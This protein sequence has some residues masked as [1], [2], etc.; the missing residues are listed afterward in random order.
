MRACLAT[1]NCLL[2]IWLNAWPKVLSGLA[3]TRSRSVT[4][5]FRGGFLTRSSRLRLRVS[6]GRSHRFSSHIARRL[7]NSLG[8]L[9]RFRLVRVLFRHSFGILVVCL[10]T[11]SQIDIGPRDTSVPGRFDRRPG[12]L[13]SAWS[14]VEVFEVET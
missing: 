7:V 4:A 13:G 14:Q 9:F 5:Q 12:S 8:T 2:C 1:Q 11:G 10:R 6:S 3:W